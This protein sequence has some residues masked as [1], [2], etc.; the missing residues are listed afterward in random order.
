MSSATPVALADAIDHLRG[1][2]PD[3]GAV[4]DAV[5]IRALVDDVYNA[6]PLEQTMERDTF[7]DVAVADVLGI[8][9][10]FGKHRARVHKRGATPFVLAEDCGMLIAPSREEILAA[11][12]GLPADLVA[13]QPVVIPRGY[14]HGAY[15][16]RDI[17]RSLA[18]MVADRPDEAE[19]ERF[20]ARRFERPTAVLTADHVHL[21]HW[22]ARHGLAHKLL[23]LGPKEHTLAQL[24]V[25]SFE[26]LDVARLDALDGVRGLATA[27]A[28][29]ADPAE[30]R[31]LVAEA[32]WLFPA[33]FARLDQVIARVESDPDS[34]RLRS[35]LHGKLYNFGM[36]LRGNSAAAALVSVE[37]MSEGHL[38]GI[39]GGAGLLGDEHEE[40]QVVAHLRERLTAFGFGNDLDREVPEGVRAWRLGRLADF[41]AS[42]EARA[43]GDAD[44]S[45][46]YAEAL[47]GAGRA[48]VPDTPPVAV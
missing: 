15:Q 42:R 44:W 31:S 3:D 27:D 34:P 25:K 47:A 18:A 12:A 23:A 19:I 40:R 16:T 37:H 30:L 36:W 33:E 45:S 6:V 46:A 39:L 8:V 29:T 22:T 14:E 32:R 24:L 28:E 2:S 21:L 41:L 10:E 7:R 11:A 4:F 9:E 20:R 1:L 17:S 48:V 35:L 43:A 38:L 5:Q 26:L 13:D